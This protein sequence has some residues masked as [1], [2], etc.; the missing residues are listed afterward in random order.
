MAN[1][2]LPTLYIYRKIL[3]IFKKSADITRRNIKFEIL[4]RK[5]ST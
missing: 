3:S 1:L 2:F 5:H 4:V